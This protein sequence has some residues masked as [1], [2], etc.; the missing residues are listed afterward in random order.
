MKYNLEKLKKRLQTKPG[1][2]VNKK[3]KRR[4]KD[5]SIIFEHEIFPLFI[6]CVWIPLDVSTDILDT[7]PH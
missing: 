4:Y 5:L 2:F 3:Y 6:E 1:M 7:F